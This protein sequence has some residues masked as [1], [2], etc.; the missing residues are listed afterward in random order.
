[1][2]MLDPDGPWARLTLCIAYATEAHLFIKD[3]NQSP[4]NV[5]T[6]LLLDDFNADQIAEMNR[7]YGTPLHTPGEKTRFFDFVGG[8]PY[9]VQRGLEVLATD[10]VSLTA[11]EAS[12]ESDDGVFGD[13]LRRMVAAIRLDTTLVEAVV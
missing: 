10:K 6:R 9:L 11:L 4:F 1:E 5:G 2:R 3:M 13:T 8:N 12:A 7:R